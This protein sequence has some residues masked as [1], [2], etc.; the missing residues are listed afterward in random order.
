MNDDLMARRRAQIDETIQKR[1]TWERVDTLAAAAEVRG[2]KRTRRRHILGVS[3]MVVV[4]LGLVAKRG[5]DAVEHQTLRSFVAAAN[6]ESPRVA[7]PAYSVETIGALAPRWTTTRDP[8]ESVRRIQLES[9][10]VRIETEERLRV[11]VSPPPG[12]AFAEASVESN[13]A[14]FVLVWQQASV[15][16]MSE[17][18]ALSVRLDGTVHHLASGERLVLGR[19]ESHESQGPV[20]E[21]SRSAVAATRRA[22]WKKLAQGGDLEAARVALRDARLRDPE[23]LMLAADI[24]RRGGHHGQAERYLRRVLDD[25]P[26]HA[27]APVA[28]FTLGKLYFNSMKKPAEAARMFARVR[29]LAGGGAL[30]EDAL[31]REV[32]SWAK[33]GRHGEARSL[34]RSYIEQHP[35]GRHAATM[36]GYAA[37]AER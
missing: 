1:Y 32:E 34:A 14:V 36:R 18:G 7:Q 37:D 33:A 35:A 22:D 31:V 27:T 28:A 3:A 8:V 17:R 12:A 24:L 11:D 16:V 23:D 15:V 13:H 26:K 25:H 20:Q 5:L 29:N 6:H 10:D 4:C 21:G 30:A 9:G 19:D 2:A